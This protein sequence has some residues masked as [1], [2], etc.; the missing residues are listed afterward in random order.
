M[1][2]Q[3]IV[4]L[5][6]VLFSFSSFI[7][8]PANIEQVGR[9]SVN[10]VDSW[11]VGTSSG[12]FTDYSQ[13]EFHELKASGIGCIELGSRTFNNKNKE[14]SEAFVRDIKMKADNAGIEIWSVHLPF[15]RALDISTTNEEDR[16][17]MIKECI[18]KMAVCKP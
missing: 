7:Q 11:K 5:L 3:V 17:N 8:P 6:F 16:N 15:S 1:K 12:V 14:E 9:L 4:L 10:L 2:K 13:K 18:R